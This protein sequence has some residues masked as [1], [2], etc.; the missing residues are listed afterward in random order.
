MLFRSFTYR[1]ADGTRTNL[2][3]RLPVKFFDEGHDTPDLPPSLGSAGWTDGDKTVLLYD[4]FDVWE[5]K[6]DGTGARMI[7]GGEGRK[8]HLT[9]RYRVP[10]DVESPRTV[11]TTKPLLLST[12]NKD[13]KATGY[14]RVN[15]AGGTPEKIVMIDKRIGPLTKAKNADVV[16]FT[17]QR[18]SEFPDLWVSDSNFTTPKKVSNVNPQQADYVMGNAEVMKY[19]IG[20]AH[21]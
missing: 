18:F 19:K 17:E 6:P 21:V 3:E 2:T 4:E 13:T 1:I 16:V 14:Y 15:Y 20:R 7:T 10:L 11:V 8:Q 12:T 9:F 5:V